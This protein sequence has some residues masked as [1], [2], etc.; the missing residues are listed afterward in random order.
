MYDGVALLLENNEIET[1]YVHQKQKKWIALIPI[2]FMTAVL[3]ICIL[4][5]HHGLKLPYTLSLLV[6][7]IVAVDLIGAFT[8]I[9]LRKVIAV[10]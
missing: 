1:L 9:R 3:T 7:S 10:N 2:V 8:I 4:V 5:V 6:G